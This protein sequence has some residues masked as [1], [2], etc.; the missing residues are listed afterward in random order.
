MTL[1][2]KHICVLI[3]LA[4]NF[5]FIFFGQPPANAAISG[6]PSRA[7]GDGGADNADDNADTLPRHKP[8]RL[9]L[10][11]VSSPRLQ[12]GCIAHA[13]CMIAQTIRIIYESCA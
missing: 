6:R 9:R 8:K 7:S 2:H 13:I 4:I 5:F 10:H 11:D 3:H 1:P 12:K